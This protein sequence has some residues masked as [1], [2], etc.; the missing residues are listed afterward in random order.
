MRVI[1]FRELGKGLYDLV[2]TLT[3]GSDNHDVCCRLFGDSVLKNGLTGTERT[4][5]KACTSLTQRVRRVNGT[6]T[7][8]EQFEWTRFLAISQDG[9][10]HRPFLYHSYLVVLSLRIGQYSHHFIDGVLT[11]RFNRLH[12]VGPFERHHNLV[13]LVVL[14]Y[15]SKP[16]SSFYSV[17]HFGNRL[18]RPFLLRVE[19]E[20]ILTSLEEHACQFVQIVLQTVIVTAEQTGTERY[21]EHVACEL[22]FVAHFEATRGL[23]DLC[24]YV[25]ANDL[26][27]LRHQLYIAYVDVANFVLRNRTIH[28]DGHQVGNNSFNFSSSHKVIYDF[29]IYNLII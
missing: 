18:E 23:E 22:H 20:V 21:L 12:G 27:D 5:D 28:S 16:R 8:F 7:C 3:A 11:C 14:I 17:S 26:D 6:H 29:I 10:L 24:I 2:G 1:E 19:R 4:R 13:R 9:F 25:S 15:L